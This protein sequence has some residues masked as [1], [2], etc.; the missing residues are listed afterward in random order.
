MIEIVWEFSISADNKGQ[1]E[2]VFGPG[3]AW[4]KVYAAAP[5]FR[6][7]TVM[8]DIG[9]AAR[10]LVVSVWDSEA[11]HEAANEANA[12][13]YASLVETLKQLTVSQVEVGVFTVIGQAGVRPS[14]KGKQGKSGGKR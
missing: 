8:R 4:S 9:Q 1:L 11:A 7:T 3:G 12:P 2:L 13:A 6:G 14:F 5:G 10:Y